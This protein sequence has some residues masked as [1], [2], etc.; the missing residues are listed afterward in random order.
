[1][2]EKHHMDQNLY[3]SSLCPILGVVSDNVTQGDDVAESLGPTDLSGA[4][5]PVFRAN[6]ITLSTRVMLS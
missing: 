6:E 1:M 2:T 4:G 5:R 3:I